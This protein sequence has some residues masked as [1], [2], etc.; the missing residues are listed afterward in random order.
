MPKPFSILPTVVAMCACAAMVYAQEVAPTEQIAA[1]SSTNVENKP[2]DAGSRE[3]P[4]TKTAAKPGVSEEPVPLVSPEAA[5]EPTPKPKKRS[6][7][8]WLFGSRKEKPA[9]TPAP[10]PESPPPPTNRR[11]IRKVPSTPPPGVAATAT[12]KPG[13]ATPTAKPN[14]KP[15]RGPKPEKPPTT[16]P[17]PEKVPATP[18]PD[19]VAPVTPPPAPP[20]ATPPGKKN[21]KT[22]PATPSANANNLPPEPGA[23]ADPEA[24]EKYRFEVAK[25]KANEDPQVK[26]LKAKADEA[27]TDADSRAALRAYNKALFEKVKKID[28]GVSEWADRLEAA[29]LKRLSE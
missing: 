15:G 8:S 5:P 11:V 24:K 21:P 2:A 13:K 25:A 19:K 10:G 12:P 9:A 17:K 1:S 28:S 20:A 6:F 22:K 3:K 27:T 4:S 23:D 16:T 14:E 26:S 29:I 7:F 18:K